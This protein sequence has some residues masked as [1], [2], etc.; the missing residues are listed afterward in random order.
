MILVV[1]LAMIK[2]NSPNSRREI[3]KTDIEAVDIPPIVE[4]TSRRILPRTPTGALKLASQLL[5]ILD[6]K[7]EAEDRAKEGEQRPSFSSGTVGT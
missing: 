2:G 7:A 5:I 6:A 4:Q 1:I 3:T